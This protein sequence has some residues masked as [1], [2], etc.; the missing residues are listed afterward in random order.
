MQGHQSGRLESYFKLQKSVLEYP[1]V[2]VKKKQSVALQGWIYFTLVYVLILANSQQ[3]QD[4]DP[5]LKWPFYGHTT[6]WLTEVGYREKQEYY[7][8]NNIIIMTA[9][10]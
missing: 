4:N 7:N 8:V 5:T 9:L 1:N 10:V 6:L 2:N 3:N